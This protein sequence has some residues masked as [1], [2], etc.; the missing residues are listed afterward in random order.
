M[1]FLADHIGKS[2]FRS[3]FQF[4]RSNELGL[5]AYIVTGVCMMIAVPLA[6]RAEDVLHLRLVVP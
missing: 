1:R 4:S 3:D 2:L 6:F 5:R